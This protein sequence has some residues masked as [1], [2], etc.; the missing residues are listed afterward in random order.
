MRSR[1]LVQPALFL[2][3]L[4]AVTLVLAG[5]GPAYA[6]G[7]EKTGRIEGTVST[8]GGSVKLPGVVVSIRGTSDQEVAQ[9]VSDADG[10]FSAPALP[11]ARYRVTSTLDGFD[12][13]EKEAVVT[14]GGVVS[15]A[16]ELAIAEVS[17]HVDVIAAAPVFATTTMASSQTVAG[18][19]ARLLTP[20]QS[21]QSALRL[22]PAVIQIPGGNSID[23]GRPYEAGMQLGPVMLSDTAT[24]IAEIQLPSTAVDTVSV[25]PNPYEVEYGRF[26][27][28]LVVV[29]TN[30]ATDRWKFDV[31]SLQPSLR[32]KRFT[33]FDVT[34]F[35]QW[36]PSF[37]IGGPLVK[38]RVFFQQSAQYRY[39]T[40]DIPSRPETEL[41][42]THLFTSLSRVDAKLSPQHSLFAAGGFVP[43]STTMATLGTF[44]PPDATADLHD[45]T[46]YGIVSER[47]V[48]GSDTTL[49]ST[50]SFRQHRSDTE[51]QGD[52]PMIRLPE[53]TLGNFFN[54]QHRK[55]SAIQWNETL[56]HTYQGAGGLHVLKA[57]VD[58]LHSGFDGTSRSS[59]IFIER[60]DGTLARRLDFDP[61]TTQ[62]VQSTDVAAFAQDRFQPTSWMAV[63]FG[64]RLDRDGITAQTYSSPRAG[65]MMRLNDAGTSTMHGGYGLFYERTPS[66][67]GAFDQFSPTIDTHYDADGITPLG[68]P[69]TLANVTLPG[70]TAARSSTWDVGFDH[71]LSRTMSLHLGV[72][73]R[74]GSHELV[75]DPIRTLHEGHYALS[76]TGRS[77]YFQ[78]VVELHIAE[79]AQR[80]INASYV[81]SYAREDL[82]S[83]LDFVDDVMQPVIS[84]NAYAPAAADAPHRLLVRGRT[85]LT[86]QWRLL[87]TMEWRSGLPY[88]VV[89]EDLEFVGPRNE[90]RFPS[91]FRLDIGVDRRFKIFKAK[92]WL[93]IRISNALNSFLPSDVQ[94]NTSSP[95]FGSFYNSVWREYRVVVRF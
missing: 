14:E 10:H 71:Q 15:L 31:D 82:N 92:P 90:R 65:I 26:S 66:V 64:L 29:Q 59:S 95:L 24:N 38:D 44:V 93:G 34:G 84:R 91:Y 35:T 85:L 80:D 88:S 16:F 27:S 5:V 50:A 78:Q 68:P 76:S 60:S 55:T 11:P 19:D 58:L 36:Q 8:G 13:A 52:A 81:H 37:E 40:A 63:Q 70:L 47:A 51:G 39:Q 17:E 53:T 62:S 94:A 83:L 21:V 89:D 9:A 73:D 4:V 45:Q 49:E 30:R 56:T 67:T 12:P 61:L 7:S 25:L 42:T 86:P 57:G 74:E 54:R 1:Q 72:L 77:S 2:L 33:V 20:G 79:G 22:L 48:L 69:V 32:V 41:K 43:S 6:Q 18:A 87:G 3:T 28:G 46:A 23:G 75:V